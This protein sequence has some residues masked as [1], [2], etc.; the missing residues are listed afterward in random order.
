MWKMSILETLKENRTPILLAE[1]GA[2]LH[3]V[4][5]FS[6]EFLETHVR[7]SDLQFDYQKICSNSDFFENTRLYEMLTNKKLKDFIS[8]LNTSAAVEELKKDIDNFCN[9]IQKHTWRDAP[10]GLCKILADAHGIVSGIDKSLAGRIVEAGKQRKNYIFR[11]TAFGYEKEIELLKDRGLKKQFFEELSQILNNIFTELETKEQISYESYQRFLSIITK[12]YSKTIGETRRSINEISL[13]D[14]AYSIASLVKSNLAK[15]LVDGWYEPRSKSKWTILSVNLDIPRLLSKGLKIG[16]ILGYREETEQL[17]NEIKKFV[18]Y[19]YPFGNEIYRDETG[20]YFSSPS[21]EEIKKFLEEIEKTFFNHL[22]FDVSLHIDTSRES[23]S[24]TVIASERMNA[25]KKISFPHISGMMKHQ[26]NAAIN[27]NQENKFSFEKCPVCGVRM[28]SEKNDRCEVCDKRYKKRAESWNKDPK[29]TVWLD[30]VSDKNGC[31]AMIVGKFNLNK[32]LSGELLD[33]L[34][35][36]TF[37]EWKSENGNI[38]LCS[39]LGIHKIEDLER[40]FQDMFK[41]SKLDQTGK[42]LCESLVGIKIDDFSKLW[43]SLAERDATGYALNLV[44]E[45]EKARH[46]IKLLF[47][48]H[49]SFARLRRIWSTTKEFIDQTILETIINSFIPSNPRT[50]RIQ[51][52]ISPNPSIP[53][54]AT[55]DIIVGG[56]RFSPVCIDNTKGIFISTTNLEILSKFGRT[57]E[58]IAEALSGQ[59]IKLKTEEEKNWKDYMI[60]EAKPADDEFQDYIPYIEIYDFP[61]QFMILVPAYE[62]LDIAEK[63]LMEYEKQFSKVRDRLPFHLGIIAFHRRTPLYIVMDAARR[64]LKRF[65][66]SKT[67]EADVIKVEDIA[68]DSELGKCKKLVLQVDRRE[69]PLNWV[70]S[71]S[72]KDPEVEDLWYP[73]LRICSAEKP[74]RA[75]CFD[76]TGSGDY[77]VHIKEIKEKD[78][79]KIEPSYLKLCYI[80]E[81]SDRFNVDEN[82]KFIDDIHHIKNLW[83]MVKRNLLS[84]KWTLSQLYSFWRELERVKEYD[85]E[86]FEYFLESNLINILGL[87]PSSGEFEFL[88]KAI[89]DGL[90]ELC[91]HWNLQVRK[92][93][94]EKGADSI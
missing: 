66:M 65:E 28:K 4:G 45:E 80:E 75:L 32:W 63:I 9:F 49:P 78:R 88:K 47:R 25:L 67:I 39:K 21:F 55:C 59:N 54:N 20:I 36:T 22:S 68:G 23:R 27:N 83:E 26:R 51:L 53:K 30:E 12:Y 46:L 56:V 18:E 16:D 60:I 61:D 87:N 48:K 93:K 17:F 5:R 62:A 82:L 3:L 92:E 84:K 50:K 15:M 8:K 77:V 14:Y 85:E 35:S 89:E 6:K 37:E 33:T 90:F 70:V 79:I 72:T 41:N 13:Y 29:K 43:N 73:Y 44:N 58:E 1:I 40:K 94:A 69:I 71:Y 31:V 64:L 10:K 57:V 86:T 38:Q 74:D 2:Y 34:I 81:S 52:V 42:E 7:D 91:L 19:D 76:Y 11:S 24:M